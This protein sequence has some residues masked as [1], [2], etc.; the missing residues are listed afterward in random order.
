MMRTFTKYSAL[1]L[2]VSIGI[3]TAFTNTPKPKKVVD[4]RPNIIV[5]LAD[6]LG[7]SDIGCYGG[8]IKTPNIDYLASEGV[9][10]KNFYNTS[11][12]CPT[13]AALLTGLYNHNAG[14]GEMTTDRNIEGYRGAITKNTVTLA[15]VLK[16]AGYR[17]AMSGKWHVSNTI[18]QPT[19]QA[20]LDW[21]N[22]KTSFPLFSPIDQYPT[23]RGFEKFFGT[24]WGV[25]DFF[26]PFSL[27][28]GTTPIKD[29]PKDYYHTD[30]IN[31]TAAT[32]IREF[33]KGNKPFFLYVAENAPHWPL[34]AKPEDIAKY[35]DTYKVGWD[36]IREARYK[37]MVSMGLIDPKT[38]PLSLRKSTMKWE[39]NPT[40]AFDE[41]AMA[42]H[43][44]MIDRMDQGV[45][46]I[47]KTLKETNQL[48]NTLIIFLSDNGASPEDAM[49]Y[50]PGFDRPSETRAGDKIVY[51][52]Y[53]KVMPGPQTSY[54]SIG[55]IW[56]NVAN[57]PYQLAKAQSY[58]G[59][60]H[61]PMIAFWPKGI[62]A[63]RG[64]YTDQVGH[65]MD[66]MTTFV[67][68]AN[69]KYPEKYKGNSIKPMQGLSLVPALKGKVSNG[70]E[71]L[72]NE[73]FNAS[74]VRAGDWKMVNLSDDSTWHLYNIK[75]DRTELNDVAAQHPDKV[76]ELTAKWQALAKENHVLPKR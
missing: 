22:H 34:Q 43:A 49:R 8:E 39:D 31:D 35:K 53:K 62:T 61:T 69:A 23:S 60:V 2:I 52:I 25:V 3:L 21:L 38:A 36:A 24:L 26:D 56:A 59:G 76:K 29:V 9:R 75:S 73:H 74:F 57:T 18:E 66:F 55:P 68:L 40:K 27:V 44:A 10:F 28:S 67:E 47:I 20:Q 41:M 4:K 15:E 48:D 71:I 54:T 46:R 13:R 58:E 64:S 51:P 33:S 19:P 1:F 37:K 5:I 7:F 63:K 42:V 30:A 70:H 14:I 45:G 17:T 6:D 50:G 65:V 32:Y 12:C 11:R 16:D 72:F